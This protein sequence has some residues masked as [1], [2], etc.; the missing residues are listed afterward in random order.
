MIFRVEK[1]AH[2]SL[3]H[4]SYIFLPY[5]VYILLYLCL[6][7]LFISDIYLSMLIWLG[8]SGI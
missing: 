4:L 5:L 1:P 6:Y 3:I 2:T 8:M 7:I